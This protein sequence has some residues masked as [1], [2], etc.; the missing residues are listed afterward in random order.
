M[1]TKSRGHQL[2][3]LLLFLFFIFSVFLPLLSIFT[4][5]AETNILSVFG[6]KQFLKVITNSLISTTLATVISVS[7]A[8]VAAWFLLRSNLKFKKLLLIIFTVP[9]LIPSISHGTGLV[10]LLGANG[11][12]TNLFQLNFNI[13]GLPGIVLG[14]LLYSFPVALL[15]FYDVFKYEDCSVYTSANIL[16]IPKYSQ[17]LRITLPYLKKPLISIFFAVFTL[18][19]TDYGVP[20]MV[21]GKFMTL[22]LYMYNEVIGLLDFGKG[23]VIGLVLIVPAFVA[24]IIDLLNKDV[25]AVSFLTEDY[26]IVK[27]KV[28]DIIATI[29][30]FIL[31][32]S[33]IL[34]IITFAFLMFIKKY[35]IIIEFSMQHITRTLDMGLNQYLLNSI[36]IAIF[37]A[38]VGTIIAYTVAYYTSRTEGKQTRFFHLISMVTLAIPGIVLGLSYVLFF[39]GSLIY[40]TL[41]ILILVNIVHFFSSPYL[42]A[43]N[44]LG[45]LNPNYENVAKTL[46][47]KNIYLIKDIFIPQT[48]STILEMF[49]YFFVNA[50]VTISAVSFLNSLSNQPLALMIP[51]LE[52]VM[53]IESISF[54]S[55]V[56][57][58][59]NL[60]IKIIISV[61]KKYSLH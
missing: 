24:F 8:A 33:V 59:V 50:M 41:A 21:G 61:I 5:V 36:V 45:K 47:I 32:V 20:L 53:L 58:G 27:N 37:T 13:Y 56:I 29:Y 26:L 1:K 19:F 31:S 15:M 18:I 46:G 49:A 28:R 3:K 35:P 10:V 2:I 51:N 11:V 16:G 57:L 34:P 39:K 30:S 42:M 52:S 9:M 44:A 40:G 55:I 54:V 7:F 4:K 23:A 48:I 17:L 25:S 14:S 22:P 43:Y 60:I 6:S 12:L 38:L